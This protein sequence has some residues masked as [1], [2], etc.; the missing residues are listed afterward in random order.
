LRFL[1]WE[2][3]EEREEEEEGTCTSSKG[4]YNME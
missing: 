4:K 1:Q 2:E 3:E